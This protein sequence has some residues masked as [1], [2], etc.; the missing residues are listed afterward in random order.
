MAPNRIIYV[1]NASTTQIDKRVLVS[2]N[3]FLGP[4]Y[5]N[6]S[7]IYSSGLK[8]KEAIE[9]SRE[10]IA[11]FLDAKSQEIIFTAGGT[12]A[13]NLAIF[14][15]TS[16][17]QKGKII[18]TAIEHP[19]VLRPLE[20]L[21]KNGFEIVKIKPKKNGVIEVEEVKKNLDRNTVLVSIMYAN[22]EI[23]TIQPIAEVAKIIKKFNSQRLALNARPILFHSDACQ[24]TQYLAMNTKKLGADMMTINGSKIHGPKGTGVLFV[25]EGVK[26]E[27]QTLGGDQEYGLRPGTENV[28]GIVGLAKA[29]AL[30]DKADIAKTKKIRDYIISE[31]LK[32]KGTWL[33]GCRRRRLPNNINISFRGVE[34]ESLVLYLDRKNI[35][36]STG[37]ACSSRSLEPSHVITA[38]SNKEIAHSSLRITLGRYNTL[39]EAKIIVSEIKKSVE[40]LRGVS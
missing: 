17:L 8:A 7:S 36:A 37:S 33:N 22:N 30:I 32:I 28:A 23:G 27:P 13:N 9:K 25:K 31:L 16:G 26:I 3:P 20:R 4:V 19:S 18:T 15:S 34:G 6:P 11:E 14:G 39:S 29:V 21:E 5:A 35:F 12:E 40:R 38:I 24:A 1:D 10:M 2:M